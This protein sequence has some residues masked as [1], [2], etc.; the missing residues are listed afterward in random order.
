MCYICMLYKTV[1]MLIF[2]NDA[3]GKILLY[4]LFCIK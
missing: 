2:Y 4:C 1:D 3:A